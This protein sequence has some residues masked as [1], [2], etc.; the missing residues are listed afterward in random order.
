MRRT[1]LAA[2]LS[3]G[4]LAV[5]ATPTWADV[6]V[7]GPFGRRIVVVSSPTEVQVGP[8]VYVVP[9]P[10]VVQ[11]QPWPPAKVGDVVPLPSAPMPAAP[12]A[13]RDFAKTFKPLPG[14]HEV[15]FL[16][17]VSNQPVSVVFVLPAGQPRVSCFGNS[18]VFDYGQ[19]EV[20]I[21]FKIGGKVVVNY[22]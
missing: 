11:P 6:I 5:S 4:G 1:L 20:E 17:P 10:V 14:T 18:L 16:H 22:R 7:S 21:R 8:G 3:L 9:A 19:H 13:P 15:T 2:A 12:I